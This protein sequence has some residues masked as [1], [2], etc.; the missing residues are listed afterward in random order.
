MSPNYLSERV[1]MQA[2]NPVCVYVMIYKL[3]Y[4]LQSRSSDVS[5][6]WSPSTSPGE[7]FLLSLCVLWLLLQD[8]LSPWARREPQVPQHFPEAVLQYRHT[9]NH[10]E[11][12]TMSC[13]MLP[14]WDKL[15]PGSIS[16]LVLTASS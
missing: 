16:L 14:A 12:E 2:I 10:S 9:P 5:P 15:S 3:Q 1:L 11:K 13:L 4:T 6:S 8:N 7:A